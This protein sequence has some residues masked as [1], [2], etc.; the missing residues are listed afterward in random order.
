MEEHNDG[1]RS[2]REDEQVI[3]AARNQD[4]RQGPSVDRRRFLVA[5]SALAVGGGAYFAPKVAQADCPSTLSPCQLVEAPSWLVTL[6]GQEPLEEDGYMRVD[7][8]IDRECQQSLI[9]ERFQG[10]SGLDIANRLVSTVNTAFP[11]QVHAELQ[12]RRLADGEPASP[13]GLFTWLVAIAI[14]VGV[15][16]GLNI[17]NDRPW[18]EGITVTFGPVP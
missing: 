17:C 10:E 7:L 11:G 18:N 4:K 1:T 8:S 5:G 15:K 3:T 12:T 16:I 6:E 2:S 14:V 9:V 13:L